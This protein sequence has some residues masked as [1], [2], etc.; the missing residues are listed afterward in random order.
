VLLTTLVVALI[1]FGSRPY[2]AVVVPYLPWD[3]LVHATA[4]ASFATLAWV[5]LGGRSQIGPVIIA[6]A[7]GLLD[8]GVQYYSPGRNADLHDLMADL[9]GATIIVLVLRGLQTLEARRTLAGRAA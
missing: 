7:I 1:Y 4:Y 6:G 5:G 9:I 8:E 2:Y 3:K